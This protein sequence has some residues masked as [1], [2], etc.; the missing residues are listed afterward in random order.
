MQSETGIRFRVTPKMRS[1]LD[2][3]RDEE[4]INVSAWV[5]RHIENALRDKFPEEFQQQQD[6]PEE[7]GGE[8]PELQQPFPGWRP[9]KVGNG[10]WGAALEGPEVA[11]LPRQLLGIQITVTATTTGK[12]WTGPIVE[13]VD[14]SENL[15]VVRYSQS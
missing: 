12:S 10:E 11:R 9:K 4:D 13:V 2:R 5:R 6:R 7:T 15:V 1:L 8:M 3:L 14:R